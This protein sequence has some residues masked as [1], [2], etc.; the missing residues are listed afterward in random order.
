VIASVYV[1]TRP[2]NSLKMTEPAKNNSSK[3]TKP[4]L[5]LFDILIIGF[6]DLADLLMDIRFAAILLLVMAFATLFGTV[7]PQSTAPRDTIDPKMVEAFGENLY[8]KLIKPLGLDHVFSTIWYRFVLLL[9]VASVTLCA[10]A[11]TKT[12]AALTKIKSVLTSE[13]GVQSLKNYGASQFP[14]K[15]SALKWVEKEFKG[16]GFKFFSEEKDGAHHF[17][18]RKNM[19]SKW[20]LVA[21]H[22][23]FVLILIGAIIGGLFGWKDMA[24]IREGESW[25]RGDGYGSVKLIDYWMEF[26]AEDFPDELSYFMK[27]PSDYKS[28]VQTLDADGNVLNEKIIEVN[29]PLNFEGLKFYQTAWVF[30]P[31]LAIYKNGELANRFMVERDQPFKLGDT[32]IVLF[33]P[34][35]QII[36]GL[37]VSKNMDGRRTEEKIPPTCIIYE[38]KLTEQ[39]EGETPVEPVK[40]AGNGTGIFKEG[41]KIDFDFGENKYELVFE[42]MNEYTILEVKRDPG[43]G[44]VFFG[45][46]ICVI[47]ASWGLMLPYGTA[48]ILLTRKV[49]IWHLDWG[50]SLAGTADSIRR[51]ANKND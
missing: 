27:M 38:M 36:S 31:L 51:S 15:E 18:G 1:E 6:K 16:R 26:N 25:S 28:R 39:K 4:E 49:N 48:R 47:G 11:R 13:K 14:D 45:F 50:V 43:V 44:I 24:V 3:E 37:K 21:M 5:G 2:Y 32:D 35:E 10:W 34:Y 46:L 22:Y 17:L 30:E 7:L 19:A 40:L 29:Y 9:L 23:S 41:E 8:V 20:M 42:G 33:V 12:V